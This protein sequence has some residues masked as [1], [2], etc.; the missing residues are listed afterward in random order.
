MEHHPYMEGV[1]HSILKIEW[2]RKPPEDVPVVHI[3]SLSSRRGTLLLS[4]Y[5]LK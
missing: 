5:Y 4:L 3:P 1:P 2:Y